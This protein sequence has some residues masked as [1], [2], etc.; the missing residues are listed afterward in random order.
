[1]IT[2][3]HI[4][5]STLFEYQGK[6]EWSNA[7]SIEEFMLKEVCF[8]WESNEVWIELADLLKATMQLV[9]GWWIDK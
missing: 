9:N 1:M 7:K 4:D 5:N 6:L 8:D 2:P 3:K